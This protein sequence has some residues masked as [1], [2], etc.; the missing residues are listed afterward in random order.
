MYCCGRSTD[1]QLGLGG[2]EENTISLPRYVYVCVCTVCSVYVCSV[3]V[4]G[5][6]VCVGVCMCVVCVWVGGVCVQCL[7]FLF[8][9]GTSF[10]MMRV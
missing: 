5:C 1:G 10:F 9:G 4:G 7:I 3:C 6:T 2:I 8:S